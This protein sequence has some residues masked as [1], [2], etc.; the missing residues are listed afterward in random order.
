M[1]RRTARGAGFPKTFLMKRGWLVTG[2]MTKRRSSNASIRHTCIETSVT[3]G[4]ARPN[5]VPSQAT[6][7]LDCR[8]LPGTDP[9]A[10]LESVKERLAIDGAT[11]EV[12]D[13]TEGTASPWTSQLFG[14]FE[15]HLTGGVVLPVV[16]PGSTDSSFLRRAG[17]DYVY[18]IIPFMISSEE[19]ATLHGAQER[20]RREELGA[21]LLRLTRVLLDICV[22]KRPS[23][24]S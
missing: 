1:L 2:V 5:V 23:M 3:A 12:I 6:A 13:V 15:R 9:D 7:I 24:G 11:V 8:T 17:V 10:F 16:S 20:V 14:A 22:A 4:G 21:G 18:G 19:L